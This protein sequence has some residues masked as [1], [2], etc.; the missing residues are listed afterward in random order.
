MA[1]Y[2][3]TRTPEASPWLN[4]DAMALYNH[5]HARYR[6]MAAT[7]FKWLGLPPNINPML[8]ERTLLTQNGVAAF[9]HLRPRNELGAGAEEAA[10]GRFTVVRA[11]PVAPLDDLF[12]TSG[13]TL[14]S[15]AGLSTARR[16]NTNGPIHEWGGVPIWGD[17]LRENYDSNT[18]D[19]W[20]NIMARAML[21]VNVNMAAT[22]RGV[23]M[24]TNQ[25]K[26]VSNQT[27]VETALSGL[28]TFTA[29]AEFLDSMKTLDLGVHPETV[30]RSHV[31]AMRLY[32]E[33][34]T[35]L[36]LRPGAQ[37]KQERLTDDEVQ[38]ITGS[39]QAIRLRALQPRELAAD[40]IN[41]RYFEGSP[42]VK[43][44]DQW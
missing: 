36:G 34:L 5:Y 38:A 39:A 12:Y 43:V 22:T 20:A 16:F 1:R 8:M 13:Y 44:V 32:N 15:P 35:A 23:V 3:D 24:V 6:G 26:L 21:V 41:H 14:Y 4:G 2:P 42:V 30:E 31:V 18:I 17:A 37:E 27:A 29:D 33:G 9:V 19:L 25:D 10:N 7:R 11:A 28:P 40:Q